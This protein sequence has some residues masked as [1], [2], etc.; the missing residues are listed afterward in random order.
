[1]MMLRAQ[2]RVLSYKRKRDSEMVTYHGPAMKV[3][4][5]WWQR[6]RD[7][8]LVFGIIALVVGCALAFG[9]NREPSYDPTK[10]V[11]HEGHLYAHFEPTQV[12]GSAD[13]YMAGVPVPYDT[14]WGPPTRAT[15][16]VADNGATYGDCVGGIYP[17]DSFYP[18]HDRP[19]RELIC[20]ELS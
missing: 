5:S 7:L 12:D 3:G 1:M 17:G 16:F 10:A 9:S 15:E 18:W 11:F 14:L 13:R 8:V 6:N 2:V 19:Y 20:R 4:R